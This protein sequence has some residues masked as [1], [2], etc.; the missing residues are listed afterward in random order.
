MKKVL[1]G[2]LL[3]STFVGVSYSFDIASFCNSIE[4]LSD[5]V[6][7][8]LHA[9]LD[10]ANNLSSEELDL[11]CAKTIEDLEAILRRWPKDFPTT[12]FIPIIQRLRDTRFSEAAHRKIAETLQEIF[13]TCNGITTG[14]AASTHIANNRELCCQAILDK[15]LQLSRQDFLNIVQPIIE[16][17]TFLRNGTAGMFNASFPY[18]ERISERLARKRPY[19]QKVRIRPEEAEAV[20]N[21]FEK[22]PSNILE[23][24]DIISHPLHALLDNA[25]N[26][27][28]EE[29][30]SQCAKVIEDLY[31]IRRELPNG[32]PTK[33]FLPIIQRLGDTRFSEAIYIKLAETFQQIFEICDNG[34]DYSELCCRAILDKLLLV[35][36]Q[37][38]SNIVQPVIE[39][40]TFLENCTNGIFKASFPY[41]ER[42][43]E[44][45]ARKGRY[46]QKIRVSPKEAETVSKFFEEFPPNVIDQ[47]AEITNTFPTSEEED[48]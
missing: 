31:T 23:Q 39:L 1:L 15:L 2:I 27:S 41:I 40:I 14:H 7:Q 6:S 28:S 9:L 8:P 19:L 20:N 47:L 30:D 34:T 42:I 13:S 43:S 17:I 16:L 21:F 18:I 4:Q 38:F 33:S 32:F 11:Q 24:L 36:Q 44:N 5:A 29:L 3:C 26:L 22:F 48:W 10:N 46:L 25:E 37:D 45:I 35:S 12:M